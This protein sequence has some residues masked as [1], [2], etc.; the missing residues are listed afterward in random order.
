MVRVFG[1]SAES[2]WPFAPWFAVADSGN[3]A[4]GLEVPQIGHCFDNADVLAEPGALQA[5]TRLI[6]CSVVR[7][8]P[9]RPYFDI[10]VAL[11]RSQAE[12]R[13]SFGGAAPR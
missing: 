3:G 13:R 12:G 10:G 6:C 1:L 7:L 4:F 2:E 8:W 11:P 9:E 5:T